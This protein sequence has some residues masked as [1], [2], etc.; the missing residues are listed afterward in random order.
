M[1]MELHLKDSHDIRI[2]SVRIVELTGNTRFRV[3]LKSH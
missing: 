2:Q 3:P 1:V